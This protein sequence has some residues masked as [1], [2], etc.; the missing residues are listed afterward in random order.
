MPWDP[1]STF[2]FPILGARKWNSRVGFTC[3]VEACWLQPVR[4]ENKCLEAKRKGSPGYCFRNLS[5]HPLCFLGVFRFLKWLCPSPATLLFILLQSSHW[6][7]GSG[8]HSG[9]CLSLQAWG[10]NGCPTAAIPW[11]PHHPLLIPLTVPRPSYLVTLLTNL[12]PVEPLEWAICF[13]LG[14]C[15]R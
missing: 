7:T 8:Q 4:S 13:Q 12:S 3:P 14:P 2:L 9:P 11:V 10:G 5:S 6:K 15:L 1:F